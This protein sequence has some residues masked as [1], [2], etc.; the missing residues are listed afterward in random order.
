MKTGLIVKQTRIRAGWQN[1]KTCGKWLA[2]ANRIYEDLE[3]RQAVLSRCEAVL[4]PQSS[5]LK[6][7]RE[8]KPQVV[9]AWFTVFTFSLVL[10][11][12][13]KNN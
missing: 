10:T 6:S 9:P 2:C 3:F 5:V 11:V 4:S 1:F 7:A 13:S 12:I 8:D